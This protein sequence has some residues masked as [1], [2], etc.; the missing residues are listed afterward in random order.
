MRSP[1]GIRPRSGRTLGWASFAGVIGLSACLRD[2][3]GLTVRVEPPEAAV[4]ATGDFFFAA[5][6][7]GSFSSDVEWTVAADCGPSGTD[8][9]SIDAVT[10]RYVAPAALPPNFVTI[11]AASRV[12]GA[13]G[14]ARIQVVPFEV[15]P[16]FATTEGGDFI[17]IRG[18]GFIPDVTVVEFDGVAVDAA[19]VNVVSPY[20]IELEAPP[21]DPGE[22]LVTLSTA[23]AILSWPGFRYGAAVIEFGHSQL[24]RSCPSLAPPI[25]ADFDADGRV[26]LGIACT[27][28]RQIAVHPSTALGG[29]GPRSFVPADISGAFEVFSVDHGQD[30]DLDYVLGSSVET[31]LVEMQSP[32]GGAPPWP[33]AQQS[34]VMGPDSIPTPSG[35]AS[36]TGSV[37]PP[38]PMPSLT[39]TMRLATAGPVCDDAEVGGVAVLPYSERVQLFCRNVSGILVASELPL[40]GRV[41]SDAAVGDFDGDGSD[42]LAILYAVTEQDVGGGFQ[43]YERNGAGDLVAGAVINVSSY[44]DAIAAGDLDDDG[45]DDVVVGTYDS[46][47]LWIGRSGP[48]GFTL[49]GPVN[50]GGD[51]YGQAALAIA[52]VDGDGIADVTARRWV[53]I[54]ATGMDVFFGDGA[55]GLLVP[56][57]IPFNPS[58]KPNARA[59]P[60]GPGPLR[61]ASRHAVGGGYVQVFASEARG[62]GPKQRVTTSRVLSIVDS[63]GTAVLAS[64]RASAGADAAIQVFRGM[65]DPVELMTFFDPQYDPGRLRFDDVTGDGQRDILFVDDA[66]DGFG[67]VFV[68]PATAPLVFDPD[69]VQVL[70]LPSFDVDSGDLDGDGVSD[71]AAISTVSGVRSLVVAFGTAG[72][73]SVLTPQVVTGVTPLHVEIAD[74]GND[75]VLE[76]VAIDQTT[77]TLNVY[78]WDPERTRSTAIVTALGSTSPQELLVTALG[79]ENDGAPDVVVRSRFL[80]T[81]THV[82]VFSGVPGGTIL[83]QPL[84][85]RLDE[86]VTA[87]PRGMASADFDGDGTRDLVVP[88]SSPHAFAVFRARTDG[89]LVTPP[90]LIPFPMQLGA[91]AVYDVDGDGVSDLFGCDSADS[92]EGHCYYLPNH[93]R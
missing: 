37:T 71:L 20:E 46:G 68:S 79:D 64:L 7:S 72:T 22:A 57:E 91:M 55:G 61:I 89:T 28:I 38:A 75:G 92:L 77:F 14:T 88:V 53:G 85:E 33:I 31:L 49:E 6:V 80:G 24:H 11:T 81:S 25:A 60:F 48:T 78:R 56:V 34:R 84:S 83:P 40:S 62:F 12:S 50:G 21:H 41:P 47:E 8:C 90:S 4:P 16:S 23:G 30:G 18:S 67:G 27:S 44:V 9:G 51:A 70:S 76:V 73:L 35:T 19:D 87:V 58:S 1:F 13:I 36:A 74:L 66:T 15:E 17:V 86:T 26:D 65:E 3:T 32:T 52:D 2:G 59:L 45:D 63:S 29:F 10:G 93:S 42:E 5:R 54:E 39:P 43:V 82:D 69:P